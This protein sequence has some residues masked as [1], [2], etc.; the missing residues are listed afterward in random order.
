M[1]T[2]LKCPECFKEVKAVEGSKQFIHVEHADYFRCMKVL[3]YAIQSR[4]ADN[5]DP[6]T[7]VPAPAPHKKRP[8]EAPREHPMNFDLIVESVPQLKRGIVWCRKCGV[9]VAT[10]SVM[11]LCNGWPKCCGETMTIDSPE[12]RARLTRCLS[13]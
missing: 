6:D 13:Q 10:S 8:T 7:I 3:T 1:T 5:G 4:T 11:N 12:E 2:I 9:S